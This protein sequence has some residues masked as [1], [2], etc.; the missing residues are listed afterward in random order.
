VTKIAL[1]PFAVEGMPL[2]YRIS[3]HNNGPDTAANVVLADKPASKATIVSVH[4]STGQCAVGKFVVCRLGNINAGATVR[5][6]VTLIPET[7]ESPFI[8]RAVAGG[9]T[10]EST[11][12]NNLARSTLRLIHAPV[13]PVACPSRV[14]P[15]AHPAC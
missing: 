13:S 4:P 12:A 9:S 5:I 8:N 2:S 15:T 6:M 3:V 1:S 14:S 11:L 7:T 10:A